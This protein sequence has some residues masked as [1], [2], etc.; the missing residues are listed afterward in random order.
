MASMDVVRAK[1]SRAESD[2]P[3]L[4]TWH[5]SHKNKSEHA[6]EYLLS[7]C[8]SAAKCAERAASVRRELG[9]STPGVTYC[10]ARWQICC[11]TVL[12]SFCGMEKGAA[13]ACGMTLA[14]CC[15]VSLYP[16]VLDARILSDYVLTQGRSGAQQTT[17][18]L[19]RL[20]SCLLS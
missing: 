3:R 9:Q 1:R 12:L 11:G 14:L 16:P 19:S 13:S 2:P 10:G 8:S 20:C 18:S 15:Q 5:Q 6:K 17:E 7:T 4:I